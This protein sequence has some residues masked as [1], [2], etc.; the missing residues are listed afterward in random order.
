MGMEVVVG[1]GE[2]GGMNLIKVCCMIFPNKPYY[3]VRN[4][5][6]GD[7]EGF[8]NMNVKCNR[9]VEIFS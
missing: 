5:G 7:T 4:G 8:C 6:D 9:V 2:V 1:L 3:E